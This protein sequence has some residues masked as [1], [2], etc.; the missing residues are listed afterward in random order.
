MTQK[1]I[2]NP[3]PPNLPLGS[4]EYSRQYQDQFSNVLRLYFNQIFNVLSGILGA[5]GGRF[6]QNTYG[7]WHDTTTQSAAAN[8]A[9][10]ITMNST[11]FS[12]G[13]SLVNSSKI[14]FNYYGIY[15]VQFSI[16]LSNPGTA[17]DNV[18]LWYKQN[19]VDVPNSAGIATVN[20]KHGSIPGATVF[21]WNEFFEVKPGDYLQL[22]W[23]TDS[24]NTTL[25]TY[26]AGVSPTHPASPSV[27]V[28]AQFVS[29]LPA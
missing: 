16:Q 11:D 26:A 6:F 24:G 10:L 29:A 27:A 4:N 8:T 19:G 12:Q 3:A 1:R 23:T 13:V 25:A 15:N 18:T 28:S 2:T 17:D 9:T 21:G 7:A 22:Y 20:A 14:V 5:R